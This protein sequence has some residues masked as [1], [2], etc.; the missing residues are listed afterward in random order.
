[1]RSD[2]RALVSAFLAARSE[3]AFRALYRAHSP[4]LFALALRL[5]GGRREDAEEALQEAWVRAVE[6]LESFRF[7][8]ALR[9]WLSGIV[10]RC[11]HELRRRRH[12]ER[13]EPKGGWEIEELAPPV[14][15]AALRVDLERALSELPAT[16]RDVIVLHE[17]EGLGHEEIGALLSIPAGTSKSRLHFAKRALR[18][19]LGA[20]FAGSD[21]GSDRQSGEPR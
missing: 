18:A 1:M 8:S 21:E 12:P 4:A 17:L 9:T 2:D 10:I 3:A 20:E 7:E 5:A 19:R 13:E 11:A 14:A 15:P 16:L 6:R